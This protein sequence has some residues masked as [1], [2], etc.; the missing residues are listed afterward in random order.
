M[1]IV[2]GVLASPA[3]AET[4]TFSCR[5][6]A[7]RVTVLVNLEPFVANPQDKPCADDAKGLLTPTTIGPV[8]A[9][10]LNAKTDA[11]PGGQPGARADSEVLGARISATIIPLIRADVL[12]T[13]ASVKCVDG[14]PSFSSSSEVVNLRVGS[15]VI[16]V[17]P[18]GAPFTV[19]IP[20]VGKIYGNEK[21]TSANRVT[22]RAL[23]LDTLLLDVVLAESTAN[24]EGTPCTPVPPP[25]QC[26]DGV[27][28]ADP[29]DTLVDA[30]D[31]GCLSGP[32]GSYD[33]NDD[34]ETDPPKKPQCSDTIDNDLDGVA[35]ANDPGCLSGPGGSYDPNDDDETD[36]AP[37]TQ[38]S[39]TVDNDGDGVSD[40][41][42]PGCLKPD[43][44]YDPTDDDEANPEC[45]DGVD[46][47]DP[48]DESADIFDP[49]CYGPDAKG[50]AEYKPYD[51]DETDPAPKP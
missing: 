17:P 15:L 40:A 4:G 24:I 21:V 22:R 3:A 27:D 38:C 20:L 11:N 49:G 48:E 45:S 36:P 10:A 12:R 41:A 34:D 30:N 29:E 47:L 42:D 7:A 2:S 44:T 25:K 37:K 33:P 35:D 13:S 19:N 23:R 50:N 26:S 1:A 8:T 43:G 6:S 14:Q 32:G 31:P 5:A 18:N 28:N 46:N 39:D 16:A 51:P 9:A